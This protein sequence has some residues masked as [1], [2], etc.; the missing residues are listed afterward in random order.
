[1][2]IK[3]IVKQIID[4]NIYSNLDCL[5]HDFIICLC[6]SDYCSE[7]IPAVIDLC[8]LTM[9]PFSEPNLTLITYFQPY[10]PDQDIPYKLQARSHMTLINKTQFLGH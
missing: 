10:L 2:N 8:V 3:K 5:L 4:L 6:I 1:M 7:D 9:T